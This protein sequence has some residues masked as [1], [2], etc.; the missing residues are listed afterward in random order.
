MT[1]ALGGR[2]LI[3]D[4]HL[5]LTRGERIGVV[6]PNGAG[7][8]TL[9]RMILGELE[10]LSVAIDVGSPDHERVVARMSFL[11][12]RDR[13]ASFDQAVDDLGRRNEGRLQFK[14]TGPLPAYSFVDLPAQG[15]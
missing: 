5:L 1:K 6:G 4:L 3:E 14:Y 12:E 11:V 10:P 2:T 15:E 8:T 9:L 7:K 13:L